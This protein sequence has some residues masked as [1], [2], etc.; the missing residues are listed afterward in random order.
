RGLVPVH[1]KTSN[2][3]LGYSWS[4]DVKLTVPHAVYLGSTAAGIEATFMA[5][6]CPVMVI[7]GTDSFYRKEER[8]HTVEKRIALLQTS[9]G[10]KNFQ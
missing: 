8:K 1:D 3:L 6:Q 7:A 10:L 5:I 2:S 9:V 4:S